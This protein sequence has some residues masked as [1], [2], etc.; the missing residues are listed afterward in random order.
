MEISAEALV[1][2]ILDDWISESR[3]VVRAIEI[4]AVCC[5]ARRKEIMIDTQVTKKAAHIV[6]KD[7]SVPSGQAS[8]LFCG[9][10]TVP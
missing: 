2:R 5:C 10:S 9:M 8:R 4:V 6:E 3:R 1:H 7:T